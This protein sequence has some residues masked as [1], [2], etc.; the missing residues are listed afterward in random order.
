MVKALVVFAVLVGLGVTPALPV[1]V[2]GQVEVASG[3]TQNAETDD[4][5]NSQTGLMTL[6]LTWGKMGVRS[7]LLWDTDIEGFPAF[8]SGFT[9]RP[10]DRLEVYGGVGWADY[11]KGLD[12]SYR[13]GVYSRAFTWDGADFLMGAG[14]RFLDQPAPVADISPWVSFGW[15]GN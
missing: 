11:G 8:E 12:P 2:A 6:N 7:G 15:R 5:S 10:I 1:D 9:W 13:V 14:F 4:W 3:L